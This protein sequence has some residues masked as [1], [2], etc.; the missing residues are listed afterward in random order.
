MKFAHLRH[1]GAKRDLARMEKLM[2]TEAKE[3]NRLKFKQMNR[4]NRD[5]IYHDRLLIE[6]A[7]RNEQQKQ[8]QK[9]YNKIKANDTLRETRE[10]KFRQS[11]K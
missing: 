6:E 9:N 2:D 5:I 11:I 4:L 10:H 7:N 8:L 1:E 3:Q